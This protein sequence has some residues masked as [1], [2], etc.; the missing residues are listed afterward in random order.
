MS[1]VRAGVSAPEGCP[2]IRRGLAHNVLHSPPGKRLAV[3]QAARPAE[4]CTGA[5]QLERFRRA[6]AS[7]PAQCTYDVVGLGQAMCDFSGMV[8]QDFLQSRQLQL[9]GRRCV[10]AQAACCSCCHLP[11]AV[12]QGSSSFSN[13]NT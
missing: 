1:R 6:R 13:S 2:C 7:L 8:A 9:G 4:T 10:L 12:R 3:A 11:M 5:F